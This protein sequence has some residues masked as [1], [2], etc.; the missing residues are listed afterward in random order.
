M[1]EEHV[2]ENYV[3]VTDEALHIIID[4]NHDDHFLQGVYRVVV[5]KFD[6][7]NIADQKSLNSYKYLAENM[8]FHQH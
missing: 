6:P 7:N 8:Y 2:L 3:R 5:S 1:K 4:K